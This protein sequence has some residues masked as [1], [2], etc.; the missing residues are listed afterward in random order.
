MR[1]FFTSIAL[2]LLAGES[3]A[4]VAPQPR[5]GTRHHET[6]PSKVAFPTHRSS[7]S[8]QL[9]SSVDT[10]QLTTFFLESV[11]SNGVPALFTIMV[12]AFAANAFRPK[13]DPDAG[14]NNNPIAELY[15]DLYGTGDRDGRNRPFFN[16]FLGGRPGSLVQNTG[17]P[18]QQFIRIDN[19]NSRLDSYQYSMTAA[20]QS[21][22]S[23]AAQARSRNFERA[24][25]LGFGSSLSD[26]PASAKTELLQTEQD[27]LKR[28]SEIQSTITSLQATLTKTAID[29]EMKA[30]GVTS[31][32][33]DPHVSNT[34][35]SNVTRATTGLTFQM[36]LY[37]N[38]NSKQ[39]KQVTSLQE[40]LMKLELNFIQ[41][42]ISILGP[43]RAN[44]VKAALLGDVASRGAGG[45]LTQLQDRPLTVLLKESEAG[46]ER[47]K[48]LF[49][50]EFPGDATAS[51]VAELR[52]EITA[53]VRNAKPGD[54]AMVVLQ[55][56]GGTVTGYGLAAA[57]LKRFKE[58]GMSKCFL[59]RETCYSK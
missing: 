50:T 2:L 3:A 10:Q 4:F 18:S 54:E 33:M 21:K 52:E 5:V 1:I 22:A 47:R 6:V 23:A 24:L 26:L 37:G 11:I 51:Q 27:F 42:V 15:S 12:I 32:D 58:N 55:T 19:V 56:G 13:K 31:T 44:G 39:L 9:Y 20:T 53:I 36:P 40:N 43:E 25:Q 45:L 8:T 30:L 49:V 59:A 17:V 46:G 7:I 35:E 28:A 16:K 57:Q 38:K 29:D 41:D 34:T 48:S 14:R